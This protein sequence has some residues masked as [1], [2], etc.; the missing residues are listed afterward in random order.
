MLKRYALLFI[1]GLFM[2]ANSAF[3]TENFTIRGL[4]LGMTINQFRSTFENLGYKCKSGGGATLICNGPKAKFRANS[5]R[6]FYDQNNRATGLIIN[7]GVT[8][9]C[10][11][12]VDQI[13][14]LLKLSGRF[15]EK[16]IEIITDAEQINYERNFTTPQESMSID[17][18]G[19]SHNCNIFIN[20]ISYYPKF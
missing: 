13:V 15:P 17:C 1:S 12:N 20:N 14:S 8:D 3:S 16:V 19:L 2:S 5:A 9:S 4:Q 11:F 6:M 7:C 10:Q 18:G